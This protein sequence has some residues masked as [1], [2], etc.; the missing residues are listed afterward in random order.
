MKVTLD[1][2]GRIELPS[3]VQA[4][5]GVKPGDEVRFEQ[6]EDVWII[7]SVP[8]VEDRSKTASDDDDLNWPDLDYQS[9]SPNR[10]GE[11]AVRYE[12]RGKLKPMPIDLNES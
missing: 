11:V 1:P 12:H 5:L 7:R 4:Q 2:A 6:F 10:V 3:L 9:V 8:S